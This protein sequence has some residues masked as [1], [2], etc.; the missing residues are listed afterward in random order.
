MF[1]FDLSV[2]ELA[3]L[4]N[5]TINAAISKE[6]MHS[7]AVAKPTLL[8]CFILFDL[9]RKYYLQYKGEHI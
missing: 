1:T 9:I 8:S 6:V 3:A 7:K 2:A 5:R 4:L